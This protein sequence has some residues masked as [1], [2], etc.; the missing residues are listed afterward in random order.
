MNLFFLYTQWRSFI[1]ET[2]Y[3]PLTTQEIIKTNFIIA[4]SL[5]VNCN[6]MF[7]SSELH[8]LKMLCQ[9]Q[10]VSSMIVS[11]CLSEVL[12]QPDNVESTSG[13]VLSFKDCSSLF[14]LPVASLA[15]VS[16]LDVECFRSLQPVYR[17]CRC[18]HTCAHTCKYARTCTEFL[19]KPSL[20][21]KMF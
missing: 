12:A 21:A 1:V 4:I 15:L 10:E 2:E 13:Y 11:H 18:S 9:T 7:T 17:R 8:G 6:S 19:I 5:I 20:E 3:M 16:F 14:S